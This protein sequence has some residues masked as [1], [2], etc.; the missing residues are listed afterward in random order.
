ML[1]RVGNRSGAVLIH[2]IDA[3]SKD[4]IGQI[5]LNLLNDQRTNHVAA[6][7]VIP[8]HLPDIREERRAG[9]GFNARSFA[10]FG[11]PGG[12]AAELTRCRYILRMLSMECG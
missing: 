2:Q 3:T 6:V 4:L 7:S 10:I 12:F 5:A 1:Q 8:L 9:R 11:M